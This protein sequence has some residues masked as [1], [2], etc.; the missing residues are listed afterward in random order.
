[1]L[2]NN[3]CMV[4]VKGDD[5]ISDWKSCFE[6]KVPDESIYSYCDSEFCEPNNRNQCKFDMCNLCCVNFENKINTLVSESSIQ[7]C[8][9]KCSST[10]M[11]R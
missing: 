10:F 7:S 1:M 4:I 2:C 9:K 3:Q 8:Y 11:I 6:P 5:Q